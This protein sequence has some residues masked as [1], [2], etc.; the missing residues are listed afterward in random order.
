[1]SVI[2]DRW[3]IPKPILPK[4]DPRIAELTRFESKHHFA[5]NYVKDFIRCADQSGLDW[6]LLPAITLIESSGFKHYVR[7]TNNALGWHSDASGFGSIPEGICFVSQ[8][9]ANGAY[10]R[11]KSLEAK[12]KTY[13]SINSSYWPTVQRLMKEI[14]AT[15]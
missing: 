5:A 9:L 12:V 13:N 8:Q 2:I 11:G 3:Q 10:Y 7:A 4:H 1:M 14:N 6:R 15:N